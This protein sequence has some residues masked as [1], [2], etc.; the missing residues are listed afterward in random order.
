MMEVENSV[1]RMLAN[2]MVE[3]DVSLNPQ[4]RQNIH[5]NIDFNILRYD[6]VVNVLIHEPSDMNLLNL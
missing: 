6:V 2:K 4:W 1:V 3:T 5:V